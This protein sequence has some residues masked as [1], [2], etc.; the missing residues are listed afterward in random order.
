MKYSVYQI[1]LSDKDINEVNAEQPN[2]KYKAKMDMQFDFAGRGIS[3]IASEAINNDLYTKVCIID[4]DDLDTVFN[5]GN[6]G[7]EHKIERVSKMHSIS[8]G[9]VI[10]ASDGSRN[11]VSNFGFQEVA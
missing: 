1:S 5:I 6:V 2:A 3:G 10:I 9:D 4:A 11:V 7:P 8:I